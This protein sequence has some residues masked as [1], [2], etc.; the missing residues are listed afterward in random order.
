MLFDSF[1]LEG[2]RADNSSKVMVSIRLTTNKISLSCLADFSEKFR[3]MEEPKPQE[4]CSILGHCTWLW[5]P[6]FHV[7]GV[8]VDAKLNSP[9]F[10]DKL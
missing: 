1:T 10:L 5:N 7:F 3:N 2:E 6:Q 9:E 8:A 4:R